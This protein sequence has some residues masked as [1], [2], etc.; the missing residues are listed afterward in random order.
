VVHGFKLG[1]TREPTEGELAPLI[2]LYG[3]S[4]SLLEKESGLAYPVEAP[5]LERRA[6]AAVASVMLNLDCVLTK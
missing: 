4:L 2:E 5:E 6:Y 3:D 1:A